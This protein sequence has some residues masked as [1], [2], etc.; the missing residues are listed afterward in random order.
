MNVADETGPA[1]RFR[2][3]RVSAN[4][5]G[6]IGERP[7]LGRDF[8]AEDDFPGAE[9]AVILT[10]SLWTSRYGAE[11]AVI[12]RTI[13]VNG[14]VSTVVGVMPERFRFPRNTEL[15]QSLALI[16]SD[17]LGQRAARQLTGVG[18]LNPGVTIEQAGADLGAVAA[19]LARQFP[20]TNANVEPRIRPF[21]EA[22]IGNQGRVVLYT[23]LVAVG[24]VLLI[25]CANVAN[26]LLVRAIQ[27]S[28]EISVR[29]SIGASR[30]RIIRQLLAESL[31]L[32]CSAGAVAV[33][34]SLLGV[35]MFSNAFVT[36]LEP[37][38]LEL[39]MDAQ[40][41]AFLAVV[42]L[43][44]VVL[45]GLLPA[46]HT[47]RTNIVD[48]LSQAGRASTGGLRGRRWMGALVIL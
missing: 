42:C 19:A 33:A 9:P 35:R 25:A 38:W 47:A 28:R 44:T 11:P 13:R 46:V 14:I 45:F 31:L 40:V 48:V 2:G 22:T 20:D 5:F 16:P 36:P 7:V 43:G 27:R 6:L 37:Y 15:W 29:M 32:A 39:T 41:F 1:A 3:A 21:R 23:L 8:R 34:L 26:L 17:E 24:C 12:G 18:R 10:H 30:W 4:V